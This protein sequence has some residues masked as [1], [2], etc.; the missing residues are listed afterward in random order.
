MQCRDIV[1]LIK[2]RSETNAQTDIYDTR[3]VTVS[4][5]NRRKSELNAWG[6]LQTVGTV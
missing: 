2:I 6:R 3:F 5:N 4:D 1:S